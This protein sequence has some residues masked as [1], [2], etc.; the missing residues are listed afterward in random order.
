MLSNIN[1][2]LVKLLKKI[3]T[4]LK[5]SDDSDWT[6]ESVKEVFSI[7]KNEIKKLEIGKSINKQKLIREFA[8]TSSLQEISIE[9][10]WADEY[11]KFSGEFDG[12]INSI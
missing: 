3:L 8:P 6:S 12:L 5:E 1:K 7:I 10:D 11:L 2:D 9:N 4:F